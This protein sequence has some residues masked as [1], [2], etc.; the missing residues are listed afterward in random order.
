MSGFPTVQSAWPSY[1]WCVGASQFQL[2]RCRSSKLKDSQETL[3]VSYSNVSL[4]FF[5]LIG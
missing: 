4:H 3:F 1:F 2:L 5:A